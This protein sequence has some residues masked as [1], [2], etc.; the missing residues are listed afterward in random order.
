MG[1][2]EE[3]QHLAP[4]V[5]GL[6][7]AQGYSGQDLTNPRIAALRG[8][9]PYLAA[10]DLDSPR[11]PLELRV[12]GV[13]GAPP[14]DNLECPDTL[15]VAGD[16]T[17]GF[18]RPWYPGSKPHPAEVRREA[19]CWGKL[20]YS[21]ATRAL[22]LLL[23]AFMIVN[24]AHF[25][26][27]RA[28]K[29]P[30]TRACH[31]VCRSILRL[32]GLAMTMAFVGTAITVLADLAA[33]Q[34][35]RR[36]ALPTW[37]RWYAEF[38]VG[39]RL[40][41]ALGGVLATLGVLAWLSRQTAASYE[42]W[43][44]GA[45]AV[46]DDRWPLTG[47]AFW[48]GERTVARQRRCHVMAGAAEV[49]FIAVM[50][51]SSL[52]GLRVTALVV[53]GGVLLLA[54]V[55]VA[56]PW[57][58]R[59]AVR[60]RAADTSDA[61]VRAIAAGSLVVAI[62]FAAA[63]LWW[64]PDDLRRALPGGQPLVTTIVLVMFGLLVAL[65]VVLLIMQPWR[66]IDVMG[67]GWAALLLAVLG[68]AIAT[69]F[70]AAFTLTIANLLGSPQVAFCSATMPCGSQVLYLPPTIYAGGLGMVVTI[71]V[72]ALFG[73]WALAWQT[74]RRT[75]HFASGIGADTVQ[76]RYPAAGGSGSVKAVARTWARS[77]LTDSAAAALA[78]TAVPVALVVLGDLLWFVVT[79]RPT[80]SWLQALST[81][82]GTIGVLAVGYFLVQVRSALI[83]SRGR[84]RFGLLWDV[85]TFFPRA[86]HPF[87]PPCYAERSVPELVTRIRR[88]TGDAVRGAGDPALA[89]Q[90]AD[91]YGAQPG[92]PRELH[93]PVLL[94]GYSQ[95]SPISVA[96]SAQ[97]P[98]EVSERVALLTLA[99]PVR[100]LYGRAFPAYFGRDELG[101]LY[102]RFRRGDDV[103]WRN[104]VRRSDY[105][106]GWIFER[107]ED[108]ASPNWPRIDHEILDPP[109]LWTDENP[110]PPP[111]HLHS[112]WFPDPQT[113]PY[114]AT[115]AGLVDLGV[116]GEGS[117]GNE[118]DHQS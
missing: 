58:D 36:G 108:P 30:A 32:L 106:G 116:G 12:H 100:R 42:R 96:V 103:R 35:P 83:S 70:G 99:A 60:D 17:A 6:D 98:A 4:V 37:L 24:V 85:G 102:E 75:K 2:G 16:A 86:C 34:A 92:D 33:W 1:D 65:A 80:A 14:A 76:A 59:L 19:Y 88:I 77:E 28:G 63:R 101:V 52:L 13:G 97:L 64:R 78:V 54:I 25:A 68:T 51:H 61:I 89:M 45:M 79:S 53:A 74:P 22:W 110:T 117:P 38:G 9:V 21:S 56:A 47:R 69:V 94:V 15:Q 5:I 57:T 26:L 49:I 118:R 41:I 7:A 3:R 84:K 55:L 66:Q 109:V 93:T 67:K 10:T 8:E 31:A 44:G 113:R 115:L 20:N 81:F 27:P 95:G 112:D 50:P 23:I 11:V 62:G 18:F 111:T 72:A 46:E 114:A 43:D 91:E 48:R 104:L 82:G 40:T 90:H 87:G 29:E 107:P 39:P 71:V 73:S 105:I